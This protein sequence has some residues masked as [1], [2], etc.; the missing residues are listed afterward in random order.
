VHALPPVLAGAD[1]VVRE[2]LARFLDVPKPCRPARHSYA[3]S[4]EPRADA[5][6]GYEIRSTPASDDYV[7][8]LSRDSSRLWAASMTAVCSHSAAR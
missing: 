1:R 3:R 6:T 2:P 5:H 7:L 4:G 8:D